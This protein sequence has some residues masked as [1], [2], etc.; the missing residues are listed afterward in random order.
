MEKIKK[1][2]IMVKIDPAIHEAFKGIAKRENR[3][4]EGQARHL[5]Q[6]CVKSEAK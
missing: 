5:I 1:A 4:I 2:Y 3:S 6:E